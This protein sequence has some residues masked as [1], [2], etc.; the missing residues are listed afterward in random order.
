MCSSDLVAGENTRGE[1]ELAGLLEQNGFDRAQHEQIRTD[2]RGGRIGLAMTRLPAS[3]R[4]ED[5]GA[6]ELFD[7]ARAE[8]AI[9][10]AGEAALRRG[11]VGVITYA[12]GVGSRWTQGAGV[13]KGLHPFAKFAGR[14]RNFIDVHLAK[15]RLTATTF[16]A[17]VP[18]VFTTSHLT[19]RPAEDYLRREQAAEWERSVWL[20]PGRSIGLRLVPTVRDLHFAWQETAQQR[21]DEQKEK[22]RESVRA[23]LTLWARTAGEGTDYTDN[24]PGQCLHPVGH[25]FEVPNLLK[26]GTLARLLQVQ[27]QLKYLLAHNIDTLG[28]TLDPSL[29]GWFAGSDATLGWEVIPRRIEDHGGGLARV[30][31]R[32]L[33]SER[34]K[35][36]IIEA[37]LA[38]LREGSPSI[39]TATQIA[40]RAGY[41]VRS[42][43][44]KFPDLLALRI[45]ATDHA[46]AVGT[47]QAGPRNVEADRATR[48]A[49]QVETRA[50]TCETWLALWRAVNAN[51]GDSPEL[52]MRIKLMR[53]AI[54]G[55]LELMY[56]PELETLAEPMRRNTL[57]SLEL[58]TDFES[59]GRMREFYGLSIEQARA[60]WERA[61]DR[62]LPRT[63]GAK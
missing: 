29:V 13:V 43:F 35:Q 45:A 39:P 14:H 46:I 62:L 54:R 23:A 7:A 26:N 1:N 27:P 44:E 21:L 28:A 48:I 40:D 47:S 4:I 5:V 34:T 59:W 10:H 55:R 20:S 15:S 8:P 41:S 31:G 53:E 33:R 52:K 9:R 30:D 56:R 17:T 25:W 24:L 2:L 36:L 22:M 19:H 58:L 61:I 16:G 57:L 49:T 63:P 37:Y 50:Q 38:L 12:A 42:V 60:V 6:Q 51:Q 11:E 32:R 18:H 3:T